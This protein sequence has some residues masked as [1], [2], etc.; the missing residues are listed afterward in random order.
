MD[1]LLTRLERPALTDVRI[2][3]TDRDDVE[4]WPDRITD[5]YAGEPVLV[6]ARLR[7]ETGGTSPWVQ[8]TGRSQDGHWLRQLTLPDGRDAPGVA[9]LW[10]RSKIEGLERRLLETDDPDRVRSDIVEV[11]LAHGLVSR[12]TSLVAVDE[13]PA[14]PPGSP[15]ASRQVP[16]VAPAGAEGIRLGAVTPTATPSRIA[17]LRAAALLLLALLLLRHDPLRVPR[18]D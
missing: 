14:V 17:L 12:Y 18:W 13:T 5:L 8:L 16:L 1:G 4:T 3:W 9:A 10:A 11:A 15:T 2:D 7:G 6:A